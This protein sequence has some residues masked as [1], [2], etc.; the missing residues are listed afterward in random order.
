[1]RVAD[2][3]SIYDQLMRMHRG[4]EQEDAASMSKQIRL[5]TWDFNETSCPPIKKQLGEFQQLQSK[6]PALTPDHI[7]LHPMN[8]AF[9]IQA[10]DGDLKFVIWND[11]HPLVMWAA[12]TRRVLETCAKTN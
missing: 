2:S 12:E 5:K 9:H 4:N 8:H 7:V 10:P 11:E 6:P 1:M 3:G